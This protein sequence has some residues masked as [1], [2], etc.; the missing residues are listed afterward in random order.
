MALNWTY[1][2]Y[3]NRWGQTATCTAGTGNCTATAVQPQ[4]TFFGNTNRIDNW[5][6]DAAGNLLNDQINTYTYDAENRIAKLT[7]MSNPFGDGLLCVGGADATEQHFTGKDR[8]AESGLDYFEARYL[9]SDL[10]RFMT[11]DWAAKP[12]AVPYAD[13]GDPQSLN[14]YSYVR[15]NP[16]SRVDAD[17]H[18]DWEDVGNFVNGLANAVL[19]DNRLGIGRQEQSTDAGRLGA[20]AGD[21]LAVVQGSHETALGYEGMITGGGLTVTG[22]GALPGV[23]VVGAGAAVVAHGAA[24]SGQGVGHLAMAL[25]KPASGKGSVP[26]E[27]RAKPRTATDK[28]R[29]E[30][31]KEQGGN[32][33]H[34]DKP[35]GD[36]EGVSHHDPV[37]HSDGG[38]EQKLVHTGCH[39]DL[40]SAC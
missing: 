16:L 7:C 24:V 33:A 8:D 30:M 35:L 27:Q 38:T 6:Y 37:R 28:E 21:V 3:G 1:D 36:E 25:T 11:P 4:L 12:A 29:V 18:V 39:A 23:A 20:M 31:R 14:I 40:H 9:T 5:S 10:G 13:F 19:S 22:E 17:G 32:C 2:R 26:K 34:C 15:N